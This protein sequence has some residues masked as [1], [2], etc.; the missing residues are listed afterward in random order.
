MA[1]SLT[2]AKMEEG[3]RGHIYIQTSTLTKPQAEGK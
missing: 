1:D 2:E 3:K